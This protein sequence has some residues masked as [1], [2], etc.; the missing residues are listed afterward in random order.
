VV[1]VYQRMPAVSA[2]TAPQEVAVL[3]RREFDPAGHGGSAVLRGMQRAAARGG[4]VEQLLLD[5]AGRGLTDRGAAAIAACLPGC[6]AQ[7]SVSVRLRDAADLQMNSGM[8]DAGFAAVS[9]AAAECPGLVGLSLGYS[10]RVGPAAVS[11][12]FLSWKRSVLTEMYLCHAC[13][14]YEVEG[15][16]ARAGADLG[17]G[18]ASLRPPEV[19][20]AL[21]QRRTG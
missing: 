8:T 5:T 16:N 17:L 19:P 14:Y 21:G 2:P 1:A 20:L 15:G 11:R 10:R 13:S 18:A 12:A 9:V 4:S 7:R 3:G 6:P